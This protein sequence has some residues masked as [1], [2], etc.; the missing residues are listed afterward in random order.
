MSMCG[1]RKVT[2]MWCTVALW[3]CAWSARAGKPAVGEDKLGSLGNHRV[4][5]FFPIGEYGGQRTLLIN[6]P[7]VIFQ[8]RAGKFWIGSGSGLYSY[9]ERQN[10]WADFR[11]AEDRGLFRSALICQDRAGRIWLKSSSRR[12]RF[13]CGRA[14]HSYG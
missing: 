14:W 5:K 10:Q 1:S 2:I 8:D 12:F 6:S 4:V 11:R 9:D 13:F 7:R 3:C